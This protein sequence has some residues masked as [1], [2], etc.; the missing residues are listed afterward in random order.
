M[1]PRDPDTRV[2]WAISFGFDVPGI[3]PYAFAWSFRRMS[4]S[5]S[6]QAVSRSG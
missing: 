5:G 6:V 1:L 3:P 2:T 4:L